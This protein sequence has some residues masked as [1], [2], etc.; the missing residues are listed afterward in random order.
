MNVE[1]QVA[2]EILKYLDGKPHTPENIIDAGV[3]HLRKLIYQRH[4]TSDPKIVEALLL[5]FANIG[6]EMFN[7]IETTDDVVSYIA[8]S[9]IVGNAL[10]KTV[11]EL[12]GEYEN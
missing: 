12:V 6:I 4:P 3:K 10:Q 9:A 5:M 11:K 1:E 2:T 8:Q 7:D